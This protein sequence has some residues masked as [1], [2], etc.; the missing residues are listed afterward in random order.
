MDHVAIM[1]PV[2]KLV[3]KIIVGEKTIESRWYSNKRDPWARIQAGDIV[4]FKEGMVKA[5][6]V[7]ESV[8]FFDNLTSDKIRDILNKYHKQIGVDLSYLELVKDKKYCILIFLKNPELVTEFDI[9]KAGFGMMNAWLC[10]D[11]IN[12]IK[13]N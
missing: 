10:I 7:V 9:D 8:L 6:A 12:K 4:Y 13:K 3:D 2:W 1:K 11:N 5:R